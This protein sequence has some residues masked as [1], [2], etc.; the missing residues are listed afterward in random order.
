MS[1]NNL[2]KRKII[3]ASTSASRR[4]ML[5]R[6]SIE[7]TVEPSAYEENMAADLKPHDLVQTFSQGKA[8]AVAAKHDDAIIIGADSVAVLDGKILGKPKDEAEARAMLRSLSGREHVFLTGFT[9]I[10]AKNGQEVTRAVENTVTFRKLSDADI[11]A[12]VNSGEPLAGH[13]GAYAAQGRGAFLIASVNGEYSNML[14]LP[15]VT[16][17]QV[18]L[19]FG[20]NL[21]EQ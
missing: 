8:R 4:E 6:T 3:L 5:K 21:L 15:L 11:T 14:G 9:V 17:A 20:V 2:E 7:F 19:D 12:Y 10:D 1:L 13:A 16:L 18:M